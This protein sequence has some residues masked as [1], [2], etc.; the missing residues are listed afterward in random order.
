VRKLV[1]L[2]LGLLLL[3]MLI[4]PLIPQPVQAMTGSGTQASP[5][6]IYSLADLQN[7]GVAPFQLDAWYELGNNIDASATATWGTNDMGAWATNTSYHVDMYVTHGGSYYLCRENHTSSASIEYEYWWDYSSTEPPLYVGF[8][9]IGSHISLDP[10]SFSGHFDG[11]GYTISGLFINRPEQGVGL[12]SWVEDATIQNLT[13]AD[14]DITGDDA[15]GLAAWNMSG[16]L[17]VSNVHVTGDITGLT[18]GTGGAAGLVLWLNEGYVVNC[19]VDATV[20]ANNGVARAAG[21]IHQVYVTAYVGGSSFQGDVSATNNIAAGLI[22]TINDGEIIYCSVDADLTGKDVYGLVNYMESGTITRSY[23]E[24]T[25]DATRYALGFIGNMADV[26]VE[27]CYSNMA[28]TAGGDAA[29]FV[30]YVHHEDAVIRNSYARGDVIVS[31]TNQW[32]AGFVTWMDDGLIEDCYSTGQVTG[33]NPD[34][35]GGFCAARWGGD[36][37]NSFWDV[38]TSG[39][40]SSEGGTPASTSTMTRIA[41][42]EDV[43]GWHIAEAALPS[44]YRNDGYPVHGW[45]FSS[46]YDW[47]IHAMPIDLDAYQVVLFQPETIIVGTTLPNLAGGGGVYEDGIFSWGANPAGIETRLDTFLIPED[48]YHFEPIMPGARDIIEPEPGTMTGG[49]DLDKLSSNPFHPLA[50]VI[51]SA[52]GITLGLAWL[53][54]AILVLIAVMLTVQL[55]GQHMVFTSLAGVAVATMFYS[56]GVWGL[57]VVILLIFGLIASVVYERMPTL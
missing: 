24:G 22:F 45:L 23:A 3:A 29:G 56:I 1:S 13:L 42:Y 43:A 17:A 32:A 12:F 34:R 35:L 51:A 54:L 46:G 48:V 9:P 57:W 52:P 11:K 47:L 49:V 41:L 31:G 25:I 2:S 6:I 44:A 50:Q 16:W 27:E 36:I 26:V 28:I 39:L 53:G 14:V 5:Y 40:S 19:S 15:A 55:K 21:L 30:T 38:D 10:N 18:A 20:Q 33:T 8:A 37:T 7:V 4:V